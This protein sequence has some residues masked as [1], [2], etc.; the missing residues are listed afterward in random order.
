MSLGVLIFLVGYI[1]PI[2]IYRPI[3]VFVG[4]AVIVL[5]VYFQGKNTE[6]VAWELKYKQAEL[7]IAN[8]ETQAEIV[9]NKIV[10]K[11]IPKIRYVDKIQTQVVKQY[12]TKEADAVCTVNNGFV[13]IHDSIA[14]QIEAPP[15]TEL[16]SAASN[17][18]LSEVGEV[19]NRNYSECH[20]DK[21]KLLALQAWVVEQE[22]LWA[23]K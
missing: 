23:T 6:R 16:V 12:V 5:G 14:L 15:A 21:L 8:L 3:A 18:K 7:Q 9:T 1:L 2:G 22:K 11:Y 17:I 10:T 4:I 20:R 19:V 13:T